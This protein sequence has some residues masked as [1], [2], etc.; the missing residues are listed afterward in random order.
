MYSLQLQLL[1]VTY[2]SVQTSEPEDPPHLVTHVY[3]FCWPDHDVP[4]DSFSLI[5]FIKR[6]RKIHPVSADKPL[7]VHCSAGVGRTGTFI[8]LDSMMQR[9]EKE[10][11]V[12]VF[13]FLK[14][15]R[16]QRVLMVQT[17]VIIF[18]RASLH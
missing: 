7:L 6:V 3:Y 5:N 10:G 15:L 8:M 14:H 12:N 4:T 1:L 17:E 11:T 13:E 2:D 18:N 16:D 9:I